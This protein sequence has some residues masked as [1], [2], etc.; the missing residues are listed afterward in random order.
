MLPPT[1]A[2]LQTELSR[3]FGFK[4]PLAFA[5]FIQHGI[6]ESS[7]EG[8]FDYW[9]FFNYFHFFDF[10]MPVTLEYDSGAGK[11]NYMP[12]AKYEDYYSYGLPPELCMFGS[13][14]SLRYGYIV[15]DP[16]LEMEDYSI[17]KVA[18]MEHG[19]ICYG[20]NTV[21]G[22]ETLLAVTKYRYKHFG[23]ENE[24]YA[25]EAK[26][27]GKVLAKLFG[28]D[29]EKEIVVPPDE[30]TYDAGERKIRAVPSVPSGWHYETSLDG[31]GV[32]APRAQFAEHRIAELEDTEEV[33]QLIEQ[34]YY[35][36][37]LLAL[38]NTLWGKWHGNDDPFYEE[39]A[40]LMKKVYTK[41][42]R[43]KYANRVQTQ[44]DYMKGLNF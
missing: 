20:N 41:M 39:C 29:P 6:V 11:W 25:I 2:E 5:Q 3:H 28:F 37:A 22:L 16:N 14:D 43:L 9:T 13:M 30:K 44:I 35:G 7:K 33:E 12:N 40:L 34:G 27:R 10:N 42:N 32:L 15:H 26:E 19:V 38:R 8:F 4:I 21:S 24:T 23:R 1:L 36:S 17:G 31:I 18:E